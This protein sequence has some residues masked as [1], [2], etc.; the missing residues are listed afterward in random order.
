MREIDFVIGKKRV[1]S[2]VPE[3]WMEMSER[4][5]LAVIANIYGHLDDAGFY[6]RF[7]GIPADEVK[8]MD[9][10]YYYVLNSL[11][12][13]TRK[14][15]GVTSF[16]V[17]TFQLK[18]REMGVL[19]VKAPD[20]KLNGMTFQQFM[21]ADTFYTWYMQTK[22]RDYLVSMCCCLYLAEG[23]DFFKVDMDKRKLFWNDCSDE[24]L[25][26]VVVQ[27]SL[28]KAWLS[29]A[30]THLFPSGGEVTEMKGKNGKVKVTNTWLEIFDTLVADD[31][32]RIESY[33]RLECMDVLRIVNFKIQE[34][35]KQ[36]G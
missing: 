5:F 33:K 35:K 23:E 36:N 7:F 25:N 22:R 10:Y 4:Q 28:I 30:Y 16:I 8:R 15:D 19:T 18:E 20:A 2:Y 11:L 3:S 21:M 17:R 12:S 29:K 31:L 13:F 1:H 34:R 9:F 26:A 32:S 6:E 27:W 14:M 24:T